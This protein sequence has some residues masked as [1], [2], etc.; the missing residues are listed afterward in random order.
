MDF[1]FLNLVLTV[2]VEKVNP[3]FLAK[4]LFNIEKITVD[5]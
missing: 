1:K 2:E 3:C 4:V 5:K